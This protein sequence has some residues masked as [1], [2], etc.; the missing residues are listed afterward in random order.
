M[1]RA[2]DDDTGQAL[3]EFA[4]VLPLLLLLIFGMIQFGLVLN[5]RQSVANAA[6][7]AAATY[8]QTLHRDRAGAEAIRVAGPLRS[9]LAAGDVSYA[10]HRVPAGSTGGAANASA[11]SDIPISTDGVGR[12]GEFVIATVSYRYP[13]PIRAAIAGFRFPDSYTI[14]AEGVARIEKEGT[15]AS[16]GAAAGAGT[17]CYAAWFYF[18]GQG[19]A[20]PPLD[21]IS[22]YTIKG[23]GF[24]ATTQGESPPVYGAT[25]K[26]MAYQTPF[27][28][29]TLRPPDIEQG[30]T[31]QISTNAGVGTAPGPW[32]VILYASRI[33]EP[34]RCVAAN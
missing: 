27:G 32:L 9:G 16:G 22:G 30:R 31:I 15:A 7:A 10:L 13:S 8:A 20:Q 23:T 1:R 24:S 5:A 18:T 6:Q 11:S 12:P 33:Q 3:V 17:G 4:L 26:D 21:V 29:G 19:T 14:S 34:Q 28:G 25:G 2:P